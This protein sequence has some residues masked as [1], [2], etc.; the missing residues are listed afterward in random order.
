MHLPDIATKICYTTIRGYTHLKY[1][2]RRNL[3]K[4][5]DDLD[6][7]GRFWTEHSLRWADAR[8][9]DSVAL[10]R[11]PNPGR[12]MPTV[13]QVHLVRETVWYAVGLLI[14]QQAGDVDRAIR[15]MDSLLN[16]QFD[17]PGTVFHG[18]F[19][20]APEEPPP[21]EN[22]VEWRDYDPN[23]REFIMTVCI[24]LLLEY[25][26][27]IPDALRE[28]IMQ[29]L[30]LAAEGAFAR[31]VRPEYTNIA[32]M[33]AFMLD[34]AG[35]EFEEPLWREQGQQLA[36]AVYDLF[37]RQATFHEYNSPIYYGVDLY[38][39]ALWRRYGLTAHFRSLGE[40][41]E[42]K[43]WQDIAQFYHAGMRN[44]CGP[45]D[46]S[47]GMDMNDYISVLG[48]WI[49]SLVP[50]EHAPLPDVDQD[51]KHAGDYFFPPLIALVEPQIPA[52]LRPH[53]T[54][55]QGERLIERQIESGRVATAWLAEDMMLGGEVDHVNADRSDQYHPATVH[56]KTAS[57]LLAWSRLRSDS[58]LHAEARPRELH[59]TGE[60]MR[61]II[62]DVHA[63]QADPN[64]IQADQWSLPGL[65]VR[66]DPAAA[67]LDVTPT[68][69][70]LRV[71]LAAPGPLTLHFEFLC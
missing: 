58:L 24:I 43:L 48:L 36:Q 40:R 4:T 39:L 67:G 60:D 30:K 9:D 44:L 37:K 3:M 33:S 70:G 22:P 12:R 6:Q 1:L 2:G 52:A 45:F 65:K 41:M 61:A 5:L 28:K 59:I 49:A 35:E 14:R 8:W 29:A 34:Y 25:D 69:A 26:E 71:Q 23:W 17:Q 50:R 51:F 31:N 38:A 63:Q 46:R 68:E 62:C 53:F 20:R 10:L 21:P 18:T 57:G 64:T 66:L 7:S 19:Y 32:L 56:W 11:V 54:A 15:A 42:I 13:T 55:F 27:F 47:Y 16:Y